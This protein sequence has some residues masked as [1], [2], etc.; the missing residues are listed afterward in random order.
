MTELASIA[1]QVIYEDEHVRVWKQV[2]PE[3]GVIEKHEHAH[4]Y[5]LL[6]VTGEGPVDVQFHDGTGGP[7]GDT[8]SFKPKPGTASFVPKGHV[9]TATNQGAEY[10]AI[11]V[12]MKGSA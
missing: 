12:E 6:N 7:L 11:L 9:E 10:R 3:G 1:T 4:D 8:F 2:V 5:F